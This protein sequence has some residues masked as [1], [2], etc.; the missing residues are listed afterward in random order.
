MM[1]LIEQMSE[2]ISDLRDILSAMGGGPEEKSVVSSF[3][4]FSSNKKHFVN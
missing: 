1:E 3:D 4:M 2:E